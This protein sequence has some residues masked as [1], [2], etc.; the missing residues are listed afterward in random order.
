MRYIVDFHIH[1]RYSRAVSKSLTIETLHEWAQY[2]GIDVLGTGDFTHPLW[3]RELE[4]KLEPAEAGLFQLKE[5]F[6]HTSYQNKRLARP[7]RFML[8]SEVASIYS[9]GGQV[10]RIHTLLVA[11]TFEAVRQINRELANIGNLTADGRPIL[12]L[13]ARDLA[14]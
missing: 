4:E 2:K 14:F 6:R 5:K 3:L 12:G 1:S 11:P 10:R 7:V 8:T 13:S 9:Q